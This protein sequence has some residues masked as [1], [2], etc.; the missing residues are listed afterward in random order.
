MQVI[1]VVPLYTTVPGAP[2][3]KKLMHFPPHHSFYFNFS[4]LFS[5]HRAAGHIGALVVFCC[6]P[7]AIS[8]P[9][10]MRPSLF[11][12]CII[13]C[14]TLLQA[15]PKIMQLVRIPQ[16]LPILQK[17]NRFFTRFRVPPWFEMVGPH[18][19]SHCYAVRW[20]KVIHAAE[21][22]YGQRQGSPQNCEIQDRRRLRCFFSGFVVLI[23][24]KFSY[25]PITYSG[26][27]EYVQT[28]GFRES[29]LLLGGRESCKFIGA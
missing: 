21:K 11:R 17:L 27:L 22:F 2:T 24:L 14:E 18:L 28:G 7:L 6:S 23:S 29:W 9:I 5:L 1:C 13:W 20:E 3:H 19:S 16:K 8:A 15:I 25:H 26:Y 4:I 10:L 12:F